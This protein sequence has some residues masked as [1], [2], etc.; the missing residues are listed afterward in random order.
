[1]NGALLL[2]AAVAAALCGV[3]SAT[4]RARSIAE[5]LATVLVAALL[6]GVA[7]RAGQPWVSVAAAG[8]VGASVAFRP[9]VEAACGAIVLIAS[10]A[11]LARLPTNKNPS[12]Q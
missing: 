6:A 8:L 4:L 5:R 3:R 7:L 10:G 2:A 12:M 9:F 1:M 11:I